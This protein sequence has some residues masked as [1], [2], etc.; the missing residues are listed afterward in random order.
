MIGAED[1][2]FCRHDGFDW[3]NID[4]AMQEHQLH[5]EKP[6]RGASTISQQTARTLFLVPM[7]SW[8]RKGLETYY[9]VLMEAMLSKQR[10]LELYVNVIEF[11]EGIFGLKAA[12]TTYYGKSPAQLT[13]N[14][15]A[16]LAAILPNPKE[17]SPVKPSARVLQR[18]RRVLRLSANADFPTSELPKANTTR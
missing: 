10:I 15:M 8:V 14:Q 6:L 5:P 16:M 7:R 1:Q 17:W 12:A 4:A 9:T 2:N 18:Q 3:K 11:G 13:N